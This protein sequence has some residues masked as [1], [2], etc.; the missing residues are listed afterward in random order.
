M[1]S[2]QNDKPHS[3]E[4]IIDQLF[5]AGEQGDMDRMIELTHP[6]CVIREPETLPYGGT[7]TGKEAFPKLFGDVLDTWDVF[8]F[9]RKRVITEDN[10]A[11]V[12]IDLHAG[13][14]SGDSVRSQIIELYHLEDGLVKEVEIFYQ[15]TALLLDAL[16]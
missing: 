10:T 5:T 6:E 12:L 15:D 9:D 8:E 16:E 3:T 4:Q 13:V 11:M 14:D 2:T 1:M 7:Y